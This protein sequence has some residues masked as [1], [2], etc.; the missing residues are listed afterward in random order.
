M[1]SPCG[2]CKQVFGTIVVISVITPIFLAVFFPVAL[3]YFYV[4]Q[5]RGLSSHPCTVLLRSRSR[6]G[7]RNSQ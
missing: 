1:P 5:V 2:L 6:F 4:Q 7:F 3:V